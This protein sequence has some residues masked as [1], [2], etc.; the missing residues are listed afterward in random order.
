[1]GHI[2]KRQR[3][4]EP[5]I[6]FSSSRP[7]VLILDG[8]C[9]MEL[10]KRKSEGREVAYNLQL[11]STAALIETPNAVRDLHEDYIASG[12]HILT[13]S[14][15]A[16]SKFYLDK[17]KQ[18]HRVSELARLAVKL[19][20][21]A[22]RSVDRKSERLPVRIAGSIPP[23]SECYRSDLVP[24]EEMLAKNY[25]ELTSAMAEAPGVDLWLC[26]T[27]T[28][29]KEAKAAVA[30][31][32]AANATIPVWVSF[33]LRPCP[34]EPGVEIMDG[35]S[36]TEAAEL[37]RALGAEALLFN[38]STPELIGKALGALSGD[39]SKGLLTGGY[40]NIWE[41]HKPDWCIECQESEWGKGDQK[42]NG[43][44]LRDISVKDYCNCARQWVQ[45][46][47][48]IVGGCC[49]I[50]PEYISALAVALKV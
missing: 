28:S 42:P 32:R 9:G 17:V 4:G 37:S 15:F 48:T 6:D 20:H 50:G 43:L 18:G 49:G 2:P 41:E 16:V 1:M 47:A 5:V 24:D 11:F 21:E 13:A 46:G 27:L 23:L 25:Q 35:T 39:V 12:A 3:T 33:V 10:K 34:Q 14:T 7:P 22:I 44:A 38:C 36:I 30:A 45:A 26:E 29:R 40:G 19:A 31:C 8:G